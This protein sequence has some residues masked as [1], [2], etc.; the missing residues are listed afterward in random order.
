VNDPFSRHPAALAAAYATLEELAPGRVIIGIGAGGSGLDKIGVHRD[1]PLRTVREA[2]Q[3]LRSLLSRDAVSAETPG[4]TI[5]DARL[6]WAPAPVPPIGMAAHG[7]RMYAL[8]GSRADIILV[9]NYAQDDGLDWAERQLQSGLSERESGLR[10]LRRF[11][12][13]DVA[14][15]GSG[16]DARRVIR[17]RVRQLLTSGYYNASFLAPLGLE[18]EA[19]TDPSDATVARVAEAVAFAG[20][21]TEVRD[22][23]AGLLRGHFFDAICWRPYPVEGQSLEEAI[24]LCQDT[25]GSAISKAESGGIE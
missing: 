15:S 19:V 5:A 13:I 20:A 17:G 6:P 22:K 11:W 2:I 7:P 1:Q 16:D 9:A 25:V 3:V 4:F 18:H 21:P 10:P 8:A 12:R 14:V 24:R 23:I